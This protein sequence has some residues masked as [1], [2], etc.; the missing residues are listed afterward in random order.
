[1][2]RLSDIIEGGLS[3][4]PTVG[5]HGVCQVLG[6]EGIKMIELRTQGWAFRVNWGSKVFSFLNNSVELGIIVPSHFEKRDNIRLFEDESGICVYESKRHVLRVLGDEKNLDVTS[7]VR[8]E[9]SIVWLLL[10]TRK[11]PWTD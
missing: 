6:D 8:R 9:I 3:T 7:D 2:G 10:Q 4:S 11:F 1:M 5:E